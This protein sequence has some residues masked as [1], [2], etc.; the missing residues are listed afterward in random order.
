[1]K[2]IPLIVWCNDIYDLEEVETYLGVYFCEDGFHKDIHYPCIYY[3]D[4]REEY[5]DLIE[6]STISIKELKEIFYRKQ[7]ENSLIP[8]KPSDIIKDFPE[9]LV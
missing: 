8:M 9:Y 5:Y 1:M 4:E 6:T 3:Y 2:H 7:K